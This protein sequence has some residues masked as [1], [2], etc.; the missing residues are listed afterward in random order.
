METWGAKKALQDLPLAEEPDDLLRN[1]S[2]LLPKNVRG[3]FEPAKQKLAC[4]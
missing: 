2:F 3:P 1:F 4:K